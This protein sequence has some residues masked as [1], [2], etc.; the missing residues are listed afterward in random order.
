MM[1]RTNIWVGS[2][3]EE[4]VVSFQEEVGGASIHVKI[5][6]FRF[7][8]EMCQEEGEGTVN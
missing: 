7:P 4:A 3:A 5:Q 1:L 6:A 2:S 8:D